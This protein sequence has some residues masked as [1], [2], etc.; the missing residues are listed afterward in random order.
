MD[1]S[2]LIAR[3]GRRKIIYE[4]FGFNEK[5]KTYNKKKEK[6]DVAINNIS[7]GSRRSWLSVTFF[8]RYLSTVY[9]L[10]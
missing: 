10:S 5:N 6:M 7:P 9:A 2:V 8:L 4:T 1:H 3:K